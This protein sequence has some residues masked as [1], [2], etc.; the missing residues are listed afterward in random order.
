MVNV[1]DPVA[2]PAELGELR[3]YN[4]KSLLMVPL[5]YGG[6]SIGLLELMDDSRVRRY[7]RQELRLCTAIA[8]QAAVALHNAKA[9]FTAHQAERDADALRIA[10]EEVSREV[11]RLDQPA[12]V[13]ALLRA[14]AEIAC[15]ICNGTMCV[16]EGAGT[17]AGVGGLGFGSC[18]RA[19]GAVQPSPGAAS[20]AQLLAAS[21]PSERT[22]LTLTVSLLRA[23]YVGETGL[24]RLLAAVAGSSLLRLSAPK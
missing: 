5:V 20:G 7:S 19:A 3:R 9:F 8:S 23:P 24:L 11:V 6:H 14:V 21:D 15:R 16:V 17:S 1:G 13:D 2:D 4:D 22:D 10:I 12:E 18:E